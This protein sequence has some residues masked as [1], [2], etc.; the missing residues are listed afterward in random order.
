MHEVAR[1]MSSEGSITHWLQLLKAGD[2]DAAQPLWEA[3]FVRLVGLARSQLQGLRRKTVADEE[4]VALSAFDS[5]CRHAQ[6]GVFPRLDDR[7]DLWQVL[8]VLTVRK[9]RSLA[10]RDKRLKRG[11]GRLV[12]F[13]ELDEQDLE[14]LLAAEPTPEVA[15]QLAEECQQLLECLNDESLRGV[16]LSKLEGYTNREIANRLGCVEKTVERKLRSIRRLWADF[17]EPSQ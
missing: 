3:Y 9:A 14:A 8:L 17:G 10:R 12:T 1:T 13:A 6:N 7:D 11:A 2:R 16:A 4:D 5:F 15:L